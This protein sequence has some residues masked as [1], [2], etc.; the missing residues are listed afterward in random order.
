MS[1]HIFYILMLQYIAVNTACKRTSRQQPVP[2]AQALQQLVPYAERAVSSQCLRPLPHCN[3]CRPWAALTTMARWPA[4][5][6]F[7]PAVRA[8]LA[9]KVTARK[10]GKRCLGF[11]RA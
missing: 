8:R 11:M 2:L 5:A 7:D 1:V 4:Q 10:V 3:L 6:Q 9:G